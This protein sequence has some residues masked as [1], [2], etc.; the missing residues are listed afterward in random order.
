MTNITCTDPPH[1]K[2]CWYKT[3]AQAIKLVT[4]AILLYNNCIVSLLKD[5]ARH[6]YII[7]ILELRLFIKYLKLEI[8]LYSSLHV[9]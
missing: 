8:F 6:N 2:E 3:K 4:Y 7:T 9:K 5:I 1:T